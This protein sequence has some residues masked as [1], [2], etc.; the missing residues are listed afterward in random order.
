MKKLLC[1]F[2]VL[3][4]LA[5][6]AVGATIVSV[7]DYTWN[8]AQS[9]TLGVVVSVTGGAQ[10]DNATV[11]LGVGDGGPD[12]GGT[13]LIQ[14]ASIGWGA[15]TIWAG[16][17]TSPSTL[18]P[19]PSGAI[20]QGQVP[21][22]GSGSVTATGVLMTFTLQAPGGGLASEVG[23]VLTL[24]PNFGGFSVLNLSG[25][26]PAGLEWL[27]G[28]ITLTSQG[29]SPEPSTGVMLLVVGGL[30]FG[31]RRFRK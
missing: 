4:L 23:H 20:N 13:E 9:N 31:W 18:F 7:G 1:V 28:T 14:I 10:I 8:V 5:A 21:L 27:P 17:N 19:L 15:G 25:V 26:D 16:H 2:A 22:V 29:Q 12:A 30:W 3:C 11:T 6:P 24:D